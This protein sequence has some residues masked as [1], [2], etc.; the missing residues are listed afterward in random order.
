MLKCRLKK[1]YHA[2]SV[3]VKDAESATEIA[4]KFMRKNYTAAIPKSAN[5]Q[6]GKW[7]VE[8]DVGF[9][10]IKIA[11]IVID[12]ANGSVIEYKVP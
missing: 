4:L 10:A 6:D 7:I 12:A 9:V 5:L 3:E 8:I 1:E 11:K 2:L